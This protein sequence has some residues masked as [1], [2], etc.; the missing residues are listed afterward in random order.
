MPRPIAPESFTWG[1]THPS[2][3]CPHD[4]ACTPDRSRCRPQPKQAL[5]HVSTADVLFYGGALGGGKT[6]FDLVEAVSIAL[7]HPYGKVALFRRTLRQHREIISRFRQVVPR[8]IARYN[9]SDHVATFYQGAE[10]WFGYCDR[11][12]DVYNYQGEQWIALLLDE[13]THFTEFQ[14]KYLMTRVRSPKKG[15]RKRI[16]LTS[17]PGNVGH[18]W[19]K[20]W[21]VKPL[22]VE[23]GTRTAP[24][25]GE[26]WRPLPMP[27]DPTPPD[28]VMTRQFVPAWFSDNIAL[29]EAD[30]DYLAKAWALGPEKGKQLA[31]GDWD[32]NDS[33]IVGGS[34]RD[35]H[36]VQ[37]TD[38]TLQRHYGA[39]VGSVLPWHVL[40]DAHWRP[41]VGAHI[42]GSVDY[43]YGAPWSFH[44]HASL[45][46]GHTRTFFEFY[47]PR[48]RDSEQAAMIREALTRQTFSDQ[49]TPLMSGLQWIV[50]DP[51][52]WNNRQEMGLAKSIAE[53]Y[54]D[55][56]QRAQ[57]TKGAAGR[58]ARLSRPNR[59]LDALS[60]APDGLPW[61]S[62]T[63]ACPDLIRTVPEV[64]W[65]PDDPEV[66]DDDSE[67]HAY[68]DVGRFFEARP[69]SPRVKPSDPFA[70]LDPIS[71]AHQAAMAKRYDQGKS[72]RIVVPGMS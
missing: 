54:Q 20:R 39:R 11:E 70:H 18:G 23:L 67:N 69:H 24:Q 42:F 53:V 1:Y 25:P 48:K 29:A 30:P 16:I 51:A 17:N 2:G 7:S 15:L 47:M 41:P 4:P 10:L 45:P 28:R 14:A 52:M 43:G 21:F 27:Q 66:E 60:I 65:D 44:L 35:W 62:V 49:K 8:E 55:T 38:L 36:V 12:D 71:A 13:S 37:L 57:I 68:E 5:A 63:T 31:E 9:A 64:P 3:A 26:V 61:W 40:P 32:A 50:M 59:W 6:E 34:W 22:P 33:M 58:G 56:L 46:G 72:R 19:H